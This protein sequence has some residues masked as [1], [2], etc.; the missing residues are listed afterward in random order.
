MKNSM[1][2]SVFGLILVSLVNCTCPPPVVNHG[3]EL[4]NESLKDAGEASIEKFVDKVPESFFDK[5]VEEDSTESPKVTTPNNPRKMTETKEGLHTYGSREIIIL[6]FTSD[7]LYLATSSWDGHQSYTVAIW[8]LKKKKESARIGQFLKPVKNGLFIKNTQILVVSA[9]TSIYLFDVPKKELIWSKSLH[10]QE[11]TSL[12]ISPDWD[13]ILSGSK[14]RSAILS[15][16]VDG[17]FVAEIMEAKNVATQLNCQGPRNCESRV[18]YEGFCQKIDA[19]QGHS[20][21][22]TDVGFIDTRVI[23][24]ASND[25][26]L[27]IWDLRKVDK[28]LKE[29]VT[30]SG[31]PYGM[32]VD[33]KRRYALAGIYGSSQLLI[34]NSETYSFSDFPSSSHYALRYPKFDNSGKFIVAVSG[35]EILILNTLERKTVRVFSSLSIVYSATISPDAKNVAFTDFSSGIW[36]IPTGL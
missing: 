6:G 10:R 11:I 15:S 16:V 23:I 34:V 7:G 13:F 29:V 25:T 33:P 5:F 30:L 9:G 20:A 3:K 24:T 8:D 21:E 35:Y 32:S 1:I 12:K 27:R 18:C 26:T 36:I 14:D 2:V 17:T 31:I 4:V 19:S 22:I 28:R